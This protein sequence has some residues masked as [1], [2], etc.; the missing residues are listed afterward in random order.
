MMNPHLQQRLSGM[1]TILNGVH[2][3][4]SSATSSTKGQERQTFIHDFLERV[5]PPIYRFGTGDATDSSGE[6]SGQLDIV[7]EYP[8]APSIQSAASSSR[9]YLAESVA[10][11]IEV[12]SDAANQWQEVVRT[13]DKLERLN[14]SLG[15]NMVIG[16]APT[17]KI[18]LFVVGYTGW[19]NQSTLTEKLN[20]HPHIAGILIIDSG[21]FAWKH[22]HGFLY[23]TG[24]SSLWG[25]IVALHTI[26]SGLKAANPDLTAYAR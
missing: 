25:L 12:K 8:I 20:E 19:K 7:V 14:R 16:A 3:T 21:L 5:L 23:G 2:E 1:L 6:L 4:S 11:V 9:L 13:A 18:P 17:P 22:S 26:S 15:I 10:A 24:P